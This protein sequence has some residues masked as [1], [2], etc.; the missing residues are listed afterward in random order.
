MSHTL[1]SL[2]L[3]CPR[4]KYFACL[5]F[6]KLTSAFSL[7]RCETFIYC[8][9]TWILDRVVEPQLVSPIQWSIEADSL[10]QSVEADFDDDFQLFSISSL[11]RYFICA[12]IHHIWRESGNTILGHKMCN[13]HC[14]CMEILALL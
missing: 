2:S 1:A 11:A 7:T 13:V 12:Y 14:A 4:Q 5:L 9:V 6:I 8:T 3:P 10:H